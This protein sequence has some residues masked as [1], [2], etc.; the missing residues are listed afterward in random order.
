MTRQQFSLIILVL[1][2][3]ISLLPL[4]EH[5]SLTASPSRVLSEVKDKNNYLSVD[6]VA[7][8]VINEDSS[9]QLIDLRPQAE[10]ITLNLPGS[11]NIPY[12]DFFESD[13]GNFLASSKQK[14]IFY[15]NDDIYSTYALTLARGMNFRN[16]YVMQ[17]GL[18]EWFNTV[19]NS[20]FKG[21]RITPRENA[22]FE[23]RMKARKMFNDLNS[24]P[25]SLKI[26]YLESKKIAL[27]KLDGGCE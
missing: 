22:I 20:N 2:L 19:M 7:R 12:S 3:I 27:K 9:V 25:D 13:P 1:G 26:R 21:D 23:T 18:N 5:R 14:I 6:Q 4:P 15:S 17:G 8:F 24:L 11:V 10:F 16:T